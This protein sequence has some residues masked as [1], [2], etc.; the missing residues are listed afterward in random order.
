MLLMER[1]IVLEVGHLLGTAGASLQQLRT[2]LAGEASRGG[3]ASPGP[4]RCLEQRVAG[5]PG[6]AEA[7]T[8][9][10]A[11]GDRLLLHRSSGGHTGLA[12]VRAATVR[13]HQLTDRRPLVVVDY[14]QK[15]AMPQVAPEGERVTM[16][17]EGLKDLA[18]EQ[19]APVLAVVAADGEGLQAGHRA[20]VHHLRG[21]SALAYESDVVLMMNEK[22]DVVARHHMAYDPTA[23]ERF[24]DW[25]VLSVEKNRSGMD[26]SDLQLHKRFE[27][28]RFE[29]EAE[30]VPERLVDERLFR[31]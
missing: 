18:L 23:A 10:R 13:C 4:Q 30:P 14:L 26:G 17:V 11:Y 12:Q 7:V 25:V 31:D 1:L 8:A 6:A 2:A 24:R 9:V 22:Y 5:V 3:G 21:S 28:S 16:V 27:Q 20:R 29:P 19:Q 15:V